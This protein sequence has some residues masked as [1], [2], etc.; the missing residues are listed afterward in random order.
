MLVAEGLEWKEVYWVRGALPKGYP[1]KNAVSDPPCS[2][3]QHA[4]V[5][6]GEK[7]STIFCPYSFEAH[8]VPNGAMEIVSATDPTEFRGEIVGALMERKWA[9]YQGYGYQRDYNTCAIVL[10]RL[11]LPVP[12]QIMTGGGED[13]R[14]RG[15]KEVGSALLK[16]VKEGSKRGRFLAWFLEEDGSRSVREAMAEFAMTRSNA[17]SYLYMLQKDHGIG[18]SLV[19]DIATVVLPDGCTDPFK[20]ERPGPRASTVEVEAGEKLEV[21]DVVTVEDGVALKAPTSGDDDDSWL[22]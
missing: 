1:L 20:G 9:E 2:G 17:L 22:D 14:R 19:G 4:F 13:D 12:A 11:G 3:W 16:P 21:G 7:R 6:T 5:L 8:T 15:G 18:Y 10:R